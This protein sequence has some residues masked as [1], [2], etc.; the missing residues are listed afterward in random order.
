[1]WSKYQ[2]QVFDFAEK[3]KGHGLVEAVAG[4]GKSTTAVEMVQRF[5]TVERGL[6]TS[7][8][9]AIVDDLAEKLKNARLT[10]IQSKTYNSFGAG[11]CFRNLPKK[12]HLIN[13]QGGKTVEILRKY[14]N[15]PDNVFWSVKNPLQ[16][17]IA[18]YKALAI[19]S[20][21]EAAKRY[22]E[23]VDYYN[24][25]VPSKYKDFERLSVDVYAKHLT[26][27]SI[28]DF[29]DQK[30][31]PL[32][33][34]WEVPQYDYLVIDEYQDT[35]PLEAQ[36]M[37][38]A[39]LHGRVIAFA[40]RM[41][42]IYS[43]K[44]TEPDAVQKFINQFNATTLPLS[45]CYRCPKTVV[46]EAKSIVPYIEAA[47]NAINGAVNHIEKSKYFEKCRDR[48]MVLSRTVADLSRSVIDFLSMGRA[49]Y[50]ADKN[51]GDRLIW[52]VEKY[53][54]GNMSLDMAMPIINDK[55]NEEMA[56]LAALKKEKKAEDLES[57]KECAE[58]L[59]EGCRDLQDY[60]QRVKS[61]FSDKGKGIVHM[62][63][64]KSKGLQSG[65]GNDVYV[66]RP[67]KI[68]H[69]RA[70]L[71]HQREEEMRLKYV[72]ITRAQ[73]ELNWVKKDPSEK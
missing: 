2:Q 60:K 72:C 33:F 26:D 19:T 31:F 6:F 10:N 24:V 50:V 18:L 64:H 54:Q 39:C 25:E 44:G 5:S 57:L 8:T 52:F 32:L 29:D 55:Y 40:D 15:I 66:L 46:E 22:Q 68:P 43:F 35:S 49:A 34:N 11:L 51:F 59:F 4:S 63:I 30:L 42:A 67:D 21:H 69:K 14:F 20:P 17:I 53:V 1:M 13:E 71:P 37:L 47:P 3:G 12:A 28:M 70:T 23:I 41:Q 45:I 16:K 62:S 7:F 65:Q 58:V 61:V 48:D 9:R 27:T 38:R 56:S 73:H 36:L